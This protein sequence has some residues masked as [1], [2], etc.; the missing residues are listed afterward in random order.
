MKALEKLQEERDNIVNKY[1]T[2][3][4]KDEKYKYSI[5]IFQLDQVIDK[6]KN[7]RKN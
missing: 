3:L 1:N 4:N 2:K 6:L 7:E 5:A